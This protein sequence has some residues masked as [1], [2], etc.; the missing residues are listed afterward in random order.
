MLKAEERE[1]DTS[2]SS[3]PLSSDFGPIGGW[4]PA[5]EDPKTS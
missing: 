4:E 2:A 5:L 1:T 3:Q